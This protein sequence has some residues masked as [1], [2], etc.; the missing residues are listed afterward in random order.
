MAIFAVLSGAAAFGACTGTSTSQTCTSTAGATL[1]STA[2]PSGS[3]FPQ[4]AS[5]FPINNTVSGMIGT[6]TSVSVRLNGLSSQDPDDMDMLLVSP[7]GRAFVFWSDIG[8]I[9]SS[10][11]VTTLNNGSS[12]VCLTT[13]ANGGACS[14]VNYTITVADNGATRLPDGATQSGRDHRVLVNNTTYQPA[15]GDLPQ[16]EFF[17]ANPN[18][19]AGVTLTRANFAQNALNATSVFNGTGTFA[20][21]FNGSSN[22]NGDWKLY[23]AMDSCS[24][25]LNAPNVGSLTSWSLIVTTQSNNAATT[26]AL[27]SNTNPSSI[28]SNNNVT[29]T[30]TVTSGGNPVTLGAVTFFR[31]GNIVLGT[32]NINLNS[33]GQA[34]VTV[35]NLTEQIH[36]ITAVY[37]GANGFAPSTGSLSQTVNRDTTRTNNTFCNTGPIDISDNFTPSPAGT[38]YPSNLFVTG[39]TGNISKVT[40]DLKGYNMGQPSDTD[41]LLVGPGGQKFI[42][43]SYIGGTSPAA[44][45]V[46]FVLDDAAASALPSTGGVTS[47]TFRPTVHNNFQVSF[48]SPAPAGP[49]A[50]AA[51]I[52]TATFA[53]TFG[54]L[55]PIGTWRLFVSTH[56]GTN[57]VSSLT[58]GWCLTFTTSGDPASTTVPAV[59]PSPSA[60]NQTATVSALVTN[61]T[62]NAPVNAQGSVSFFENSTLLAG[63][64]N[65]SSIGT[66]SF[67]TSTLTQGAHFI[68]ANYS[69]APGF[70]N[71]STGR[72]L[73]YVDAATTNPSAGQFCNA[74][75]LTF[76]NVIGASGSPYPTRIN[77]SGMAGVLSKVTISLTGLSH[78]NMTR[79]LD[80]MLTGPNG[81]SLVVL[82][83]VGGTAA[84]TTP[85]NLVL[86]SSAGSALPTSSALTSG[87]FLPTD[88]SS[89]PADSF[90]PPAPTTNVFSAASTTLD[91]AFDNSNPNGLWTLW[92][93]IDGAGGSGGGS[94]TGGWCLNVTMTPPQLTINKTHVGNFT[95][96]QTG[97]QYMVVVGSN[98]PGSTVGTITVVENPPVGMTV[99]NMT[100]SG[101]S[102]TV[103]TRTCTRTST[104]VANDTFA[105]IVVTVDVAT[106]ATSP[107][108]NSVTVSGGG[109][110]GA[111]AND[112][113]IIT[114]APDLTISKTTSSTFV[115]GGTAT[116]TLIVN[117]SGPGASSGNYTISDTMPT[118]LTIALPVTGSTWDCSA[119]TTTFVNCVRGTA[120]PANVGSAPSVTVNVNIA[121]NAPASITNTATVNGGGELN[122][123]NNSGSVTNNV[124]QLLPELTI[125]KVASGGPFQ[126]GGTVSYLITVTNNGNGASTGTVTVT[127]IIPT[128]LTVTNATGANWSCSGT[129]TVSCTN[130]TAIPPSGT[131]SFT[132]FANIAA[133]APVS[134]TNTVNVSGGGDS[135]TGNNAAVSIINVGAVAPELTITKV[136]SGGPFQQGGTVSYLITVTNNGNGAS[137]GTVTVSDIIPTG[138]T[139]TNATGANWSCSGTS[140]VSCTNA[141]AIAPSG[142]SSFTIFANIAANAPVSITNTVNVSGGGDSNTGNNAGTS[143]INVSPVAPELTIT[144]VASGGPFQQGGTVS[145]LI[146]V[147]N[148]GNGASTGTVNVSDIIPTGLTVTNATGANWS[149]TGTSTVS[150]TNATAI[151]P[152]GT[153]SFSIFANI[154]ANAPASITNTVNVSGGGDSNTGNNAGTS[155]INVGAGGPN[156]TISQSTS[157]V[158]IIQGSLVRFDVTVSNL[159]PGPTTAAIAVNAVMPTGLTID[160]VG[161]INCAGGNSSQLLC[162]FPSLA[163]GTSLTFFY[164]ARVALNAPASITNTA[165]VSGGGDTTPDNNSSGVTISVAP[166]PLPDLTLT[167]LAV[168]AGP[169]TQGGTMNFGITVSNLSQTVGALTSTTVNDTMPTGLT[170]TNVSG[171]NWNCTINGGG[172]SFSCVRF[173]SIAPNTTT[174][175]I[176]ATVQ[177][178]GNAPGSITN[179]ATLTGDDGTPNNNS[180]SATINVTQR[181]DLTIS[182][183]ASGGPFVQGGTVTYNITVSNNG[184]GPTTLPINVQDVIPTG[185]T[186]TS[187]GGPNWSCT[188]GAT[189]ACI[190]E[191]PPLGAGATSSITLVANIAANAPS[192]ISNTA[193][194]ATT[195][196]SNTGNNSGTSVISVGAL[197][198]VTINVPAGISYT[199]NGQTVTGSQTF[200]VAPG[201]YNLSTTSPQSLGAGTQAVWASWS[202]GQ[203]ISHSVTVG[204]TAISITGSFTTQFQL[205]TAA[206]PSNGG[207]V[208]PVTGSFFDSGTMVNVTATPN[209][210]FTFANWT[211]PVANASA[212]ATTVTMSG[213]QTIAANFAGIVIA[214]DVTSQ[215]SVSATGPIYN[216]VTGRFSQ[217][218]TLTNNGSALAASAVAFDN[219]A[220]GYTVFTPSG[221]TVATAPAGSAYVE[222][223]AIPAGGTATVTVQFTRVGIPTLTYTRR[224]LGAGSR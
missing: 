53:N 13:T 38:P 192:S 88:V 211:G 81:N 102:C 148:S 156:L 191:I 109:A 108:V 44:S 205:T 163:A 171:S 115:Q 54:T 14:A 63:P 114:Q 41:I 182:K 202:N 45:N 105:P 52:G 33:S 106:N 159:G 118:G 24:C 34:S 50:A 104:L 57:T 145:Y 193:T 210:G 77:V 64:L 101:W 165:T 153:S 135:N 122:T 146:T 94:L 178:A 138:L 87:T 6:I 110:T 209:G 169:F 29:F 27:T 134:I 111:T 83:D 74:T 49:H 162:S 59:N 143:V 23:I 121:G 95:Q 32:S 93:A 216:R 82:S 79:D 43:F 176:L 62:T 42:P 167:K 51:P 150:C 19:N 97:A 86:D 55:N 129:S 65:L 220:A 26:T 22:V 131:S 186:V 90:A 133:D 137:T 217:T 66:A 166:R 190:R 218:L 173:Q 2:P 183:V 48:P 46:N 196:E 208:T 120:I 103:N 179:T 132:I 37:S 187:A 158:N 31:D 11:D 75:A 128:G 161:D 155:V 203:P 170:V 107:L 68:D 152:S 197:T 141:T 177:I 142:T 92:T 213:P 221:F 84:L 125:T 35:T 126:Q 20:N 136:A 15:N 47:G 164:N 204:S 160:S 9:R 7:D 78:N 144:K 184:S 85:V 80:M 201:T 175:S 36:A 70:F 72:V 200:N 4:P 39:L 10:F 76:P 127:D 119:S 98:G 60:L 30:A 17:N 21:I 168:G 8:G 89:S 28:P 212:A 172:A 5:V 139:V 99:T 195:G 140:T 199:F 40:L 112:S 61:S 117:N 147:T 185:L 91:T 1:T 219:L 100:G 71:L 157:N 189:V 3:D 206:S 198:A 188:T 130:A 96:G 223:G 56:G 124:T 18:F 149:C 151:P 180:S 174:Q 154:A 214:P 181:P 194:V 113:T 224:V 73:H 69:G 25:F 67:N 116:Y 58:G 215:L 16:D 207:T 12:N 222:V 123:S